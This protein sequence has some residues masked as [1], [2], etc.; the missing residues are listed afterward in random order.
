MERAKRF[1]DIY[2]NDQEK[3]IVKNS[4]KHLEDGEKDGLR[5]RFWFIVLMHIIKAARGQT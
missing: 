3:K 1:A 2:G 4:L 5:L